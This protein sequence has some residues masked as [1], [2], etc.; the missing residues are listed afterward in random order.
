MGQALAHRALTPHEHAAHN[1]DE[2]HWNRARESSTLY[3]P[4]QLASCQ[5]E[6][7]SGPAGYPIPLRGCVQ[8][9]GEWTARIVP[10][11][12]IRQMP[13]PIKVLVIDDHPVVRDGVE[14]LLSQQPDI[15]FV[16]GAA[17]T[18]S[19]LEAL[20]ALHPD[21]ALV[22]IKLGEDSGLKLARRIL[23]A[24]PTCRVIMLTSY[25]DE[26]YLWE[27]ARARV[28]GYLL[29]SSSPELLADTIRAVHGG[30]IRL[31]PAMGDTALREMR[32][33]AHEMAVLHEGLS[34]EHIR[35]LSLIA[36]GSSVAEIAHDMSFS[37]RTVK[38]KSQ[39]ILTILGVSSRAQAV[40]EA[41]ERGLL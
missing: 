38:R 8:A 1:R 10:E 20:A 32:G 26:E 36:S 4:A 16:G 27:A 11:G 14:N 30:E 23:H 29:K 5:S 6:H 2:R 21:V 37:E 33:M 28:H 17:D 35:V 7:D 31:S 41:Y 13:A 24:H 40:S 3:A 39:E 25:G 22:D 15:E 18:D 19:A 9:L 34:P 12:W